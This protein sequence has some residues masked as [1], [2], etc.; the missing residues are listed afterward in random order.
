MKL[1]DTFE[2]DGVS[3]TIANSMR[4][5][6]RRNMVLQTWTED[7]RPENKHLENAWV[8]WFVVNAHTETVQGCDWQPCDVMELDAL[9]A[10]FEH[11]LDATTFRV[12]N[13]W[14]NAVDQLRKPDASP[15]EK[16]D[17]QLTDEERDDPNSSRRAIKG[18][19]KS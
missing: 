19:R 8:V 18:K 13:A 5:E 10:N 17:S 6:V 16:D 9:K 15:L 2:C 12:H 1:R 4:S 7:Q 11:F 3:A 14:Y